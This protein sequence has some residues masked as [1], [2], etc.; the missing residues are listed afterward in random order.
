MVPFIDFTRECRAIQGEIDSALKR[1]FDRGSFILGPE[2]EQFEREFAAYIGAPYAV[3]VASG[4]DA[5][6]L[7]LL[8]AGVGK[9]DEVIIPVNTMA[10]T[11]MAVVMCGA[12]PVFCDCDDSFLID[13]E[14]I[15]SLITPKT[16]AIIPVHLYGRA[17]D[18][19]KLT[20]LAQAHHLTL[21]E[22]CAQ[23]AGAEWR[24][25][26]VG[27]FGDFG[28]FSFYPT[29]NLGAYGDGGA[30]VLKTEEQ[31]KRLLSLRYYGQPDRTTVIGFGINSRLDEL[32]AALLSVKLP[33]LDAW[34]EKRQA[35]AALYRKHLKDT[36]LIVPPSE[37]TQAH[38][39]HLFVVRSERRDVLR[40][41]LME[42][43][44]Q[45]LI[46][47]P[48][49]LHEQPF[50]KQ[51]AHRSFPKAERFAKEI[52]SLPLFPFLEEREV[53]EVSRTIHG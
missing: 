29:K 16:K 20:A 19:D 34:N 35:L 42:K 46:H 49:S 26:K 5:L 25:R 3:G 23:A 51:F 41:A 1:V 38:V 28:A 53:E 27:T 18:M 17:C 14:Q 43:G 24:G 48:I 45:T 22:D 7:S 40:T 11:A 36:A 13:S 21:I 37:P 9:G 12:T 2:V 4:T 33:Y 31:Q 50:F 32:Q 44:V 15:P 52:F 6:H 8:A 10:A 30:V 47:Y 39:Y